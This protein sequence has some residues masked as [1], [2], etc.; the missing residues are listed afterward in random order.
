[1]DS[2][3][4]QIADEFRNSLRELNNTMQRY[5]IDRDPAVWKDFAD[6][7][8]KLDIW[9]D[10]QKPKLT[11]A[12]EKDALQQIDVAYD[13][14]LRTARELQMK[15]QSASQ[16]VSLA[17]YTPLRTASQHL[18]DIGETLSKAHYESRKLL[19]EHAHQMLQQLRSSIFV[20]LGLLS[21][22]GWRWPAWFTG[23]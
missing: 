12:A 10:D 7:S 13:D 21:Y 2:E 20:S 16:N 8:H 17:E 19:M 5:G 9:I 4:F 15:I 23:T 18:F 3:S 14:Y 22:L 11:T 1:M 6:G